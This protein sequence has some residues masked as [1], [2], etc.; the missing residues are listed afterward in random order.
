MGHTRRVRK[1]LER[2]L[3]GLS[4]LGALGLLLAAPAALWWL[5]RRLAKRR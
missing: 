1:Q 4:R 2:A 3:D 5:V